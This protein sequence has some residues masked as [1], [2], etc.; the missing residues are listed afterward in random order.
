[1]VFTVLRQ[2]AAAG[3]PP[4]FSCPRLKPISAGFRNVSLQFYWV[5]A[6]S[7]ICC[8][9]LWRLPQHVVGLPN[10]GSIA[11]PACHQ[12]GGVLPPTRTFA[13]SPQSVGI[14]TGSIQLGS[15]APSRRSLLRMSIRGRRIAMG[16]KP[17]IRFGRIRRNKGITGIYNE[18]HDPAK[19]SLG[20]IVVW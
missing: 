11:D 17:E 14:M 16:C 4:S 3:P 6:Q 19:R 1:M 7:N 5:P 8:G 18:L 13:L 20:F 9:Q 12:G 10:F 15:R 2:N